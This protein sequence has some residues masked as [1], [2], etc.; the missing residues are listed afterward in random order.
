MASF[1]DNAE[2]GFISILG[3]VAFVAFAV[4]GFLLM[5]YRPGW[6]GRPSDGIGLFMLVAGGLGAIFTT[7]NNIKAFQHMNKKQ[8]KK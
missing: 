5:Q 3:I 6:S 8:E 4:L 1:M 2:M 7:N